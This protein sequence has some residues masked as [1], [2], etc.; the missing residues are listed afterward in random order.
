MKKNVIYKLMS[1][2]RANASAI[3]RRTTSTNKAPI[4]QQSSIRGGYPP[5]QHYPPQQQQYPPQQQQYMNQQQAQNYQGKQVPG[6]PHPKLSVSDAIAL[7]TIRLGRVE[8]FI[9]ALPP[10]DQLE[11]LG[12]SSGQDLP[13]NDNMRIVDEAVFNSI[14]SRLDRLEKHSIDQENFS[15]K[16]EEQM[17]TQ[18]ENI[19]L[20]LKQTILKT[21]DLEKTKDS[22]S[23]T[24][25]ENNEK[26]IQ[27]LDNTIEEIKNQLRDLQSL[28]LNLQNFTMSTNQ[29]LCKVVFNHDITYNSDEENDSPVEL[30]NLFDNSI[31]HEIEGDEID[32]NM[33]LVEELIN[34]EIQEGNQENQKN[35][36]E[37][38]D[39]QSSLSINI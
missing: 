22:R 34:R 20:L 1:S 10:L 19:D 2:G 35:T 36:N 29:K 11:T 28:M 37:S 16:K 33:S 9:N 23:S 6:Q 7:I 26:R 5:Q 21:E 17:K 38:G 39:E 14:V 25:S 4:Q 3:Q 30:S 24:N 13:M 8:T 32:I 12:S 27:S 31:L 18:I 15:S